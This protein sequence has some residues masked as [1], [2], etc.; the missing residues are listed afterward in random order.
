VRPAE[1]LGKRTIGW[2]SWHLK[3]KS[4]HKPQ[5]LEKVVQDIKEARP[6]HVALTGDIANIS[7]DVEFRQSVQWLRDFGGP[8]WI[9]VIPGNHDTYVKMPQA[10][11]YGRWIG[12]WTGDLNINGTDPQGFPFVRARRNI[13]LIGLSSAIPAPL[14]EASGRLGSDQIEGLTQI[15]KELRQRGF[16]RILLI[17]HPPLPGL[18]PARKALKDAAALKDVLVAQGVELVLHG[19]NHVHM[20]NALETSTGPAYILG[21]PS[22]S[23]VVHGQRPAAAWYMHDIN[24][25]GGRWIDNVVVRSYDSATGTMFTETSFA[26]ESK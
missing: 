24:R 10:E 17:H 3:R 21:V 19:H 8:E 1:L 2:C 6:D 25:R 11:G 13:A 26:L 12:Y 5:V 15:L 18:A 22:A 14:H 9:S 16:Y 4:V 23:A 7:S 20:R